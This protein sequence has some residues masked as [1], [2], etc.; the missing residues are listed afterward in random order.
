MFLINCSKIFFFKKI[1]KE[2]KFFLITVRYMVQYSTVRYGTVPCTVKNIFWN[3]FD[4]LQ[5]TYDSTV[6]VLYIAPCHSVRYGTQDLIVAR[7]VTRQSCTIFL[8]YC[9]RFNRQFASEM[10]KISVSY[11]ITLNDWTTKKLKSPFK[12]FLFCNRI[13]SYFL[14]LLNWKIWSVYYDSADTTYIIGVECIKP[15]VY[16]SGVGIWMMSTN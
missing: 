12:Y 8:G 10:H 6:L 7:A 11:I 15:V 16:L 9:G 5:G 13:K 3:N 1:E 14:P 2:G 4:Y